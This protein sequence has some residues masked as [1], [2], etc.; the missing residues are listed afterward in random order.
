MNAALE[1][2][3]QKGLKLTPQ[4]VGIV[5]FL[6]GNTSHPSANDIYRA[7]VKK[8][9]TMS[10]ATVYNTLETL[11]EAGI[12]Q[13]L[14]VTKDKSNYDPDT[15][16]H[17]HA[18]CSV[19]GAILDVPSVRDT[20]ESIPVKGFKVASVKKIYYGICRECEKTRK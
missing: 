10:L 15:S 16:A 12:L 7:L 2:L 9:P 14:S 4:R 6:D 3:K 19:C 18:Y 13:E 11:V 17:D 8:Y 20:T 1:I 5:E